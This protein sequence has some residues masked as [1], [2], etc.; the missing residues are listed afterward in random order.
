VTWANPAAN[1]RTTASLHA[2]NPLLLRAGY[3]FRAAFGTI[4]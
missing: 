3:T 1:G 2:A 4:P